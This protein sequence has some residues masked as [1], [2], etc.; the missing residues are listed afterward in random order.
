MGDELYLQVMGGKANLHK[1]GDD[2]QLYYSLI[3][4]DVGITI[5]FWTF[6]LQLRGLIELGGALQGG[7]D[8]VLGS[9]RKQLSIRS[10]VQI[11]FW[12]YVFMEGKGGIGLNWDSLNFGRGVPLEESFG[13]SWIVQET[14]GIGYCASTW[15][16]HGVVNPFQ[17]WAEEYKNEGWLFG[18]RLTGKEDEEV[19]VAL[20][21]AEA[22]RALLQARQALMEQNLGRKREELE[23][24]RAEIERARA[25]LIQ[26]RG[27]NVGLKE[28]ITEV[29][30]KPSDPFVAGEPLKAVIIF[31]HGRNGLL[32]Q[33]EKTPKG[34]AYRDPRLDHVANYL[35]GHAG[36]RIRIVGHGNR[37][38]SYETNL[39]LSEKRA[40]VVRDYLVKQAGVDPAQI[41]EVVGI[42]WDRPLP[43]I[44]AD[45][46]LN[47]RVEF[48]VLP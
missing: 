25:S 22:E 17:E 28:E 48:E 15:C 46:D 21:A 19:A 8:Q 47:R 41:V 16:L 5:P 24:V 1:E 18:L 14:V 26:E 40:R 31:Q 20:R 34:F 4:G 32:R 35:K 37:I 30:N 11:N 44:P 39:K 2:D 10:G 9:N 6:P 45:S 23:G 29:K 13:Q 42:S 43:N 33:L 36:M 27:I 12:G 3:E 7:D 38:G